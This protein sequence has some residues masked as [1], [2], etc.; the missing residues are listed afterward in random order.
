MLSSMTNDQQYIIYALPLYALVCFGSYALG[1]IGLNVM[2]IKD[3]PEA[4]TEID[5]QVKQA[6]ADLTKQGMVFDS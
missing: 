1:T 2:S 5:D 3:C 4:A 6:K